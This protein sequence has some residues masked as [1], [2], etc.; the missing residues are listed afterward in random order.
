MGS[1]T[2]TRKRSDIEVT[3][4]PTATT[5][6]ET[7]SEAAAAVTTSETAS[8]AET[9]GSG[10]M[11]S[12]CGEMGSETETRKRSDI[13]V[14]S[15]PAAGTT[16]S[17]AETEGC[18]YIQ[19]EICESQGII[20]GDLAPSNIFLDKNE[21]VKIGDLRLAKF[22]SENEL[23]DFGVKLYCAP[24]IRNANPLCKANTKSD[25]FSLGI[26]FFEVFSNFET[27]MQ[28]RVV[29]ESLSD[30]VLKESEYDDPTTKLAFK[31]AHKETTRDLKSVGYR[32]K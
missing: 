20:H 24:E 1:E 5:T 4:D 23:C 27:G 13:E 8:E 25:I 31:L 32:M 22:I 29:L 17:E 21:S 16:T 9:E 7:A 12:S 6:T 3:S 30:S 2:E 26:I 11:G 18:L 28:R 15:D 10:E 19:Q 14:T